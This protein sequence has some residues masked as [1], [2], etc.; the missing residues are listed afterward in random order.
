MNTMCFVWMKHMVDGG[1][2]IDPTKFVIGNMY[3][4]AFL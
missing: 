3:L 2:V 1:I 4:G